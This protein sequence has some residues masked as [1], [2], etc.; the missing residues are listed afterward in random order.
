MML[1]TYRSCGSSSVSPS[2]SPCAGS[3]AAIRFASQV[4]AGCCERLASAK[5][6]MRRI[7]DDDCFL[8]AI[9][10]SDTLYT[11]SHS[12]R[13]GFGTDG[14][15]RFSILLVTSQLSLALPFQACSAYA[16]RPP[17]SHIV[18]YLTRDLETNSK[19]G[20]CCDGF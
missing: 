9:I 13:A 8:S 1:Y 10:R 4:P 7:V 20:D 3:G 12:P 14:R 11:E 19:L 18:S 5:P 15:C 17:T 16:S 2:K 6:L